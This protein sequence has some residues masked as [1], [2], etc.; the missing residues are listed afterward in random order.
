MNELIQTFA[1]IGGLSVVVA[2]L[3]LALKNSAKIEEWEQTKPRLAAVVA[4]LRAAGFDPKK[5]AEK[6]RNAFQ[7][8]LEDLES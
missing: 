3:N 6:I 4:V 1:A 2:G 5:V 7:R 8:K